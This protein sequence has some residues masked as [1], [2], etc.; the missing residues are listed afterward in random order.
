MN[1]EKLEYS[2]DLVSD[3]SALVNNAGIA[4]GTMLILAIPTLNSHLDHRI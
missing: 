3:I 1:L 4:S 2:R